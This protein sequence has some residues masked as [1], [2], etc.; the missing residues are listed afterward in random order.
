MNTRGTAVLMA[1]NP[2]PMSDNARKDCRL[3]GAARRRKSV[4]KTTELR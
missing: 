3:F 4:S 1:A 2:R